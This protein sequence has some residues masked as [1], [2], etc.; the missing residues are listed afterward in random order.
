M[1]K[2]QLFRRM[3]SL[4][5]SAKDYFIE[6]SP[7]EKARRTM[8]DA[9]EALNKTIYQRMALE[10]EYNSGTMDAE[11]RQWCEQN[12]RRLQEAE[13]AMS[14]NLGV[15]RDQYRKLALQDLF[16]KTMSDPSS[17]CFQEAH[18]AIMELKAA[19]E[20]EQTLQSLPRLLNGPAHEAIDVHPGEDQNA[21]DDFEEP[22]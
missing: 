21:A 18:T 8:K 13:M 16:Y 12:I 19:V 4:M 14:Q 6:E 15:L 20:A 5:R 3:R 1:K 17:D 11:A 22:R 9:T 7:R 10:H 2:A